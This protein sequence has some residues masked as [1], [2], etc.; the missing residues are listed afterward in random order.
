MCDNNLIINI[1][2]GV[3]DIKRWTK[4]T[5]LTPPFCRSFGLDWTL[6][7]RLELVHTNV[8]WTCKHRKAHTV[9]QRDLENI[10]KILNEEELGESGPVRILVQGRLTDYHHVR[11]NGRHFKIVK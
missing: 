7:P 9:E 5:F 8:R 6:P 10:T 2:E 4:E 1:H 3:E 11:I